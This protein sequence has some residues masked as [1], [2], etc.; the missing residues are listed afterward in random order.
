MS[1]LEGFGF[2]TTAW[3]PAPIHQTLPKGRSRRSEG[4]RPE[5][6]ENRSFTVV[7]V[8]EWEPRIHPTHSSGATPPAIGSSSNA[9]KGGFQS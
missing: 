3:A 2:R 7:L 6:T 5:S 9:S 4:R 1:V 8:S